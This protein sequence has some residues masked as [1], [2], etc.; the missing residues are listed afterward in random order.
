M[1][2]RF[3][4]SSTFCRSSV[5]SFP[6]C[7]TARCKNKATGVVEHEGPLRLQERRDLCGPS[8]KIRIVFEDLRAFLGQ[9]QDLSDRRAQALQK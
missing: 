4:L 2:H 7:C 5:T 9:R 8:S 3:K 6:A 1:P